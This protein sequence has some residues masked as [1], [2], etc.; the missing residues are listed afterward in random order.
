MAAFPF[1]KGELEAHVLDRDLPHDLG[2]LS[3]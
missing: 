3:S 1:L 2:P